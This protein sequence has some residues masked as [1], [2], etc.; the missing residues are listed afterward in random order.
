MKYFPPTALDTV[1]YV[2]NVAHNDAQMMADIS[3]LNR[4]L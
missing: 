3:G 4:L 2:P 1:D